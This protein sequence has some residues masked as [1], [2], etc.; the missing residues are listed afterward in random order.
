MQ[1]TTQER[2]ETEPWW[3]TMS[4]FPLQS[5]AG[6][7][8]CL[9]CHQG[10]GGSRPSSMQRAAARVQDAKLLLGKG[11]LRFQSDSLVYFLT[12]NPAGVEYTVADK[13]H[14]LSRPLNW[15]MGAG[16]LGRTFLYET[17]GHWFQSE[18][19]LYTDHGALDTTTGLPKSS[20]TSL[21]SA[22]GQMLS[23]EDARRCF[24]CHTVHATTS[25]GFNP[26]H[27][28]AGLGCEACHGPGQ[29]HASQ[30]T[31]A[32]QEGGSKAQESGSGAMGVPAR[33]GV[34]TASLAIFDPGKLFPVDSIDFCGACHRT[35]VDATLSAGQASG[36]A[37]VRFQPYRLQ[38]SKCWRAAEDARLTCVACHNPHRALNR[39]P[40]SYDKGCLSCHATVRN[41]VATLHASKLASNGD[42]ACVTCHMPKVNVPSMHGD[43]TDH[44]IRVVRAGEGFPG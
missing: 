32:G 15:V 23:P 10:V 17:E 5:Y 27:A 40:V 7:D 38:E 42:T 37:M 29:A 13:S 22:L 12:A 20:G 1:T 34:Q 18:M 4:T 19:T 16:E 44:R 9:Q 24:S 6:S 43:F 36:T 30:M 35:F 14:K 8:A 2:L 3:P 41:E 31:A 39:D 26:L 25:A 21:L 33:T 28:E 11:P